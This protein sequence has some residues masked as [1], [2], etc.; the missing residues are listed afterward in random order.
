MS[1]TKVLV[2]L[3]RRDLRV[4]DNPILHH[5]ATATDHGFTHLLPVYVFPAHQVEISGFLQDGETSPYPPAKSQLGKFWRC[6][7][8][9]A[10]FLAETVWN[11]KSNLE[12]VG[13]DLAIRV[14]SIKDVLDH[15]IG[16]FS[17][18]G[19]S[20]DGVWMTEELSWEELEEQKSIGAVC[21]ERDIDFK[22]WKDEKYFVDDRDT[23]LAGAGDLPDVFTTYRKS[24]EPLRE[25][26]RMVLPRPEKSTLPPL[27]ESSSIPPQAQ[28]FISV[29][30]L[31]DACERLTKPLEIKLPDAP[32]PP[33]I[34]K[35][36]HSL[37]GGEDAAWDRLKYLVHCGA[38]NTYR[39]TRNGLVGPTYSTKL[40]CFLSLGS[41]TARQVHHEL[42][43][44]EKGLTDEYK[45]CPGYGEGQN[46]GTEG[47]RFELLWRDYMRLCTAKFGR[48]LFRLSGFRQDKS[49]DKVWNTPNKE[50]ASAKQKISPEEVTKHMERFQ[51]GTTGM[52]I[53][54]ASQRELWL[55]GYTSNRARQNVAS[56]FSKHLS[57]DWRYGAEW[58]EMLLVDYDVSSNWANWQYVAGVGNDP[59]GD[60]RTFNPVKQAFDYDEDGSFVRLWLPELKGV[61]KLENLFQICTTGKDELE[62]NG[63]AQNI[64]VTDPIKEI[65]FL[66]D[67]KPRRS[68]NRPRGGSSHGQQRGGGRWGH[69]NNRQGYNN[70]SSRSSNATANGGVGYSGNGNK[71]ARYQ[72]PP[73]SGAVPQSPN[74]RSAWRGNYAGGGQST[75]IYSYHGRGWNNGDHPRGRGGY[76]QNRGYWRPNEGR[77][78]GYAGSYQLGPPMLG[79]PMLGPSMPVPSVPQ[80]YY[81]PFPGG[82]L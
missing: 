35:P 75:H 71:E 67:R 49:Y 10:Q 33:Q 34:K 55:T 18:S 19:I 39:R 52:G 44:L 50:S 40:S 53:I 46:V 27:P 17:H 57:I 2:Y 6:G 48:K 82:P 51:N 41:L 64:M 32:S 20:V 31:E 7:P 13:S 5:L 68:F 69:N 58:Y 56:Y 65:E 81:M 36:S 8:L 60:A 14:G 66:P 11:L 12:A 38:L 73:P 3:L 54:D 22:I 59:R 61:Q 28:P 45:D 74:P 42:E 47:V 21:S 77:G 79:P 62:N 23:G 63:L 37:S 15:L 29:D 43:K 76:G 4:A 25:K 26:P 30:S 16:E 78:G 9:R 72:R 70:G 24:Q 1:R 80:S